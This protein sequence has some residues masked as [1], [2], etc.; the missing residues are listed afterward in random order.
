MDSQA[1]D[2]IFK[3]VIIQVYLS[4]RKVGNA[5]SF[6]LLHI[7]FDYLPYLGASFCSLTLGPAEVFETE[8]PKSI[9]GA[10]SSGAEHTW[11]LHWSEM[12]QPNVNQN[13][14]GGAATVSRK[15][16]FSPP[17]LSNP[18]PEC[19]TEPACPGGRR[20]W[21]VTSTVP[22][23]LEQNR[24]EPGARNGSERWQSIS[25]KTSKQTNAFCSRLLDLLQKPSETKID[26][27]YTFFSSLHWSS[28]QDRSHARPQNKSQQIREI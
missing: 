26:T 22:W 10:S 5:L 21:S 3:S 18:P 2:F 19:P 7:T 1:N 23:D 6:Y 15:T 25:H 13:P 16:V 12:G 28:L 20:Q 17:P 8:W 14:R 4:N 24:V 9:A 27:M 11:G